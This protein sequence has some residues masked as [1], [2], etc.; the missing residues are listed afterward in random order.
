VAAFAANSA[1][2]VDVDASEVD[3]TGVNEV[4]HVIAAGAGKDDAVIT[5]TSVP[6]MVNITMGESSASESLGIKTAGQVIFD[7]GETGTEWSY[8]GAT[9]MFTVEKAADFK[10]GKVS[11]YVALNDK[12]RST[13]RYIDVTSKSMYESGSGTKA[14]PYLVADADQL[15]A[16][17]N[18][19]PS[20]C[21]SLSNDVTVTSWTTIPS[22]SGVFDG[23][24]HTVSGLNAS[25]V[26]E[27]GAEGVV[28]NVKFTGVDITAPDNGNNGVVACINAGK[29]SS[30]AVKGAFATSTSNGSSNASGF[31][32][33]AGKTMGTS[34]IEN[35]W[36]ALTMSI[37]AGNYSTGGIVGLI[38]ET[39]GVTISRCTFAGEIASTG[40]YTQIG[41]IL[42]RKTNTNQNSTDVIRDCLVSGAIAI[43]GTNS[44]MIGGVFGALQGA[45]VSGNYVGGLTIESTSFTGSV[46][47]GTAVGGIGGV[48]CSVR[49]CFVSGSVQATNNTGSTGGSAGVVSAAKGEVTRCVVAG[50]R[51]SGT[52]LAGFST[53]GIVSKRNGNTPSVSNCFVSGALLQDDGKTI[54]G[55]TAD[56][57]AS[58]NKW[59]GVTYIN[60]GAYVS[61]NSVQDGDA[62]ASAP[63]QSDF[64]SMGYDFENI[65]KWNDAGYPELKSAG[66]QSTVK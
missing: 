46:S 65:W 48:C 21:I 16:T 5:F 32:S 15:Q 57:T 33:I 24:G 4:A 9:G 23:G 38:R 55:S 62:F 36:S 59:Y 41:G 42:G 3:V 60:N 39:D 28:Q 40:G 27:L 22:Y 12:V 1:V 2:K 64:V 7:A 17:M 43:S 58:G 53:A 54:L 29:I 30:V 37:N 45:T 49:D 51:I 56:L 20:S 66:A 31:G 63:T 14:D 25:F 47:A 35:C 44:N 18:A 52:N 61:G 34:V 26:K 19:Y 50:S 10:A 11:F 13:L 6:E 8:D